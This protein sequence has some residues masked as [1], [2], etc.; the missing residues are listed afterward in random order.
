M[1]FSLFFCWMTLCYLLHHTIQ[2]RV[3][4]A[5]LPCVWWV[6]VGYVLCYRQTRSA[7]EVWESVSCSRLDERFLSY[8][9]TIQHIWILPFFPDLHA[10]VDR[11][12]GKPY[13]P[14]IHLCQGMREHG[15]ESMA[16]GQWD[17]GQLSRSGRSIDMAPFLPTKLLHV[18]EHLNGKANTAAVRPEWL[19][20]RRGLG[21]VSHAPLLWG[22][23][24]RRNMTHSAFSG[25]I[26]IL[27]AK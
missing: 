9:L 13:S 25:L 5:H 1:H 16:P 17:N 21:P 7:L 15:Y 14:Q 27:E 26:L 4:T 19:A 10:E 18:K 23:E 20:E 3:R 2:Q 8:Y 24:C 22:V 11:S 12:W 6:S